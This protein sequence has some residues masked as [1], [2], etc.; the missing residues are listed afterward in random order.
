MLTQ[1]IVHQRAYL[2]HVEDKTIGQT[3]VV[4]LERKN[5]AELSEMY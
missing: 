1:S 5:L 4:E 3:M 2:H